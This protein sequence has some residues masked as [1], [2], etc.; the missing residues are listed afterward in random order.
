[1]FNL[2]VNK[3]NFS[4]RTSFNLENDLMKKLDSDPRLRFYNLYF[5]A[6]DLFNTATLKLGRQPLFHSIASGI[7]DGVTLDIKYDDFKLSAYYGGNVPAYQKLELTDKW[8]E[9]YIL[10]GK[11]SASF[12]K[13]LNVGIGYV[14]KNF[15]SEEYTAIRLDEFYNLDTLL[16]KKGKS[17]FKLATAE[18]DYSLMDRFDINSKADYDLNYK[19][20][21]RFEING[22]CS[23]IS[24]LGINLYY[25]YRE[26]LIR[27]NSYFTIFEAEV[28]NSQEIE[29]G[30][31]YRINSSLTAVGKFAYVKYSD[32]NSS[33]ITLGLY[34]QFGTVT[35]RKS[36][37]YAGEL[38]AVSI[39]SSHSFCDG[40]ITPSLG[41]SYS[42]YKLSPGAEKN[43]VLSIL[44]GFNFRP[45]R[46][47]S[48]DLQGQYMNNRI[49]KNDYRFFFKINYW[50]NTNLGLI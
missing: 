10:G 9:N 11:F 24:N 40:A 43:S 31:D 20:V 19:K 36:F 32:D 34:T 22:S 23:S 50:F 33:R 1:M 37:G 27:Y 46:I 21:A 30:I 18:I 8:N 16:I 2:N 49:Y 14:N 45:W 12:F 25:N 15:K 6:M 26:P 39:F 44:G 5:E 48:F 4:L 7:F 13:N 3:N 47:L 38:D 29:A 28:E 35:Y 41:L 17:E 42:G